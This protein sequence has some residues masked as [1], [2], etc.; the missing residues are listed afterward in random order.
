M[1]DTTT[2]SKSLTPVYVSFKTFLSA[3]EALEHGLPNQIDRSVFPSLSGV[4]QSQ[5]LGAFR[6]FGLIGSDGKPTRDL[7][8]LVENK[9]D[10]KQQLRKLI[11]RSYPQLVALGLEKASPNSL[12]AE[13]RNFEVT[14]NT[15]VKVKTFFLQAAKY[16]EIPL[17]PYLQKVTRTS[18]PRK[19]RGLPGRSREDI[20]GNGSLLQNVLPAG[21]PTKTIQLDNQITLSLGASA[22][23]FTMTSAD[24]TFVLGLLDQ[25]EKY[26]TDNPHEDDSDE[27][28]NVEE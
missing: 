2:E 9:A 6:F 12:D 28:E 18:A 26:E 3:I 17:S 14:G 11:E 25:M 16:A 21:G 13:I 15:L 4:V 23:L 1:A 22:D 19:R 5:L 7:H 10:R 8:G 27:E 20:G 24:R